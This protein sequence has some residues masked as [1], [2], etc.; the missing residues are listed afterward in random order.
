M[1]RVGKK[2]IA[3]PDKTK[4]TYKDRVITVKG[5][6]GSLERN[7]HPNIDLAIEDGTIS[8]TMTSNDRESRALQE[9]A[10]KLLDRGSRDEVLRLVC[11]K[12]RE[13]TGAEACK[14]SSDH[15]HDVEPAQV[16][17]DGEYEKDDVGRLRE[18]AEMIEDQ[19]DEVDARLKKLLG[20]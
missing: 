16:P 8:V 5:E 19:L 7:I 9:I 15:G 2:P 1:S 4:I 13:L 11:A 17:D 10:S 14:T 18:E 3:V 20:D 12:A 6:K